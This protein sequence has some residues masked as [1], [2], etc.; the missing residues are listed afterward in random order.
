MADLPI[1]SV[2]RWDGVTSVLETTPSGVANL[3]D[4]DAGTYV[5]LIDDGVNF[6]PPTY[7]NQYLVLD[8]A[9]LVGA[10]SI[11]VTVDLNVISGSPVDFQIHLH[12][13]EGDR[14][15]ANAEIFMTWPALPAGPQQVSVTIN[16]AWLDANPMDWLTIGGNEYAGDS[17]V[18][19]AIRDALFLGA[20]DDNVGM[21]L[22]SFTA[23]AEW[24]IQVQK[25]VVS[26]TPAYPLLPIVRTEIY[27]GVNGGM[28]DEPAGPTILSDDNNATSLRI[29]TVNGTHIPGYPTRRWYLM[30]DDTGF[31]EATALVITYRFTVVSTTAS[32]ALRLTLE[33]YDSGVDMDYGDFAGL[34]VSGDLIAPGTTHEFSVTVDQA[35]MDAHAAFDFTTRNGWWLASGSTFA[36]LRDGLMA[37]PNDEMASHLRVWT[38]VTDY[39][40]DVHEASIQAVDGVGEPV[41]PAYILYVGT[42][43]VPFAYVG[44]VDV[45]NFK[46]GAN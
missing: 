4:S 30:F 9:N 31:A 27:D 11:T 22:Q 8:S 36:A 13:N 45:D 25:V 26:A 7:V 17:S 34:T 23:P 24:E 5:T 29:S 20:A 40:I 14:N 15:W 46:A 16:Q 37:G 10:E 2:G 32:A 43:D 18:F 42:S 33:L 38:A 1:L 19:T 28:V 3:S 44:T 21:S 35:W 41:G 39:E 12:D 6:G